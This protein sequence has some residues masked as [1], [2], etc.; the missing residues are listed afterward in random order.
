M[1]RRWFARMVETLEIPQDIALHMPLVHLTGNGRARVENHRGIVE[2]TPELIRIQAA[3]G[4]VVIRG[5]GLMVKEL[6]HD[7]HRA[8]KLFP[9]ID[10]DKSF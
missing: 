2:Y 8:L 10:Y 5:R 6:A 4:L 3:T 1:A 9:D 7:D